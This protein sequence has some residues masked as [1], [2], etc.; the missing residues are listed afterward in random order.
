MWSPSTSLLGTPRPRTTCSALSAA[1]RHRLSSC[2]GRICS[3]NKSL[4]WGVAGEAGRAFEWQAGLLLVVSVESGDTSGS[5]Q[6]HRPA[7]GGLPHHH[8]A[9]R[10]IPRA[11]RSGCTLTVEPPLT[12]VASHYFLPK[13]VQLPSSQPRVPPMPWPG[14]APEPLPQGAGP[15]HTTGSQDGLRPPERAPPWPPG[16]R[17]QA[18]QPL[19]PSPA[20]SLSGSAAPALQG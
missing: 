19:E 2:S 17:V 12:R 4:W 20:N 7:G 16:R 8:S 13:M 5:P 1:S 14:R 6:A 3:E 11:W 9:P 18:P 15:Q 10:T